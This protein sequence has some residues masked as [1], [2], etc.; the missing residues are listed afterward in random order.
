MKKYIS[1]VAVLSSIQV[2]TKG[3]PRAR[4]SFQ[5]DIDSFHEFNTLEQVRDA[6]K[7]DA[8]SIAVDPS[9]ISMKDFFLNIS[10]DAL[11]E[12]VDKWGDNFLKFLREFKNSSDFFE[13]I[14]ENAQNSY[15]FLSFEWSVGG[16]GKSARI[17]TA[18]LEDL[19]LKGLQIRNHTNYLRID[20]DNFNDQIYELDSVEHFDNWNKLV[21]YIESISCVSEVDATYRYEGSQ[22]YAYIY[23]KC[24]LDDNIT[25]GSVPRFEEIP[26]KRGSDVFYVV[27]WVCP[28]NYSIDQ[29]SKFHESTD[30]QLYVVHNYKDET[31]DDSIDSFLSVTY[32]GNFNSKHNFHSWK[33][34]LD[35]LS[36]TDFEECAP[37]VL[38]Y[39][40]VKIVQTQA[41]KSKTLFKRDLP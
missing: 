27:T 24:N 15:N 21:A 9:W 10:D 40:I 7:T 37:G 19:Q 28:P 4:N 18:C 29:R 11:E 22:V 41:G 17:V 12:G 25:H 1:K 30:G 5:A 39:Q 13:F 34:Y 20:Y 8:K 31:Q 14:D 26:K 2:Q 6:L 33:A 38:D 35:W 3:R 23:F 32:D 16:C 36:D